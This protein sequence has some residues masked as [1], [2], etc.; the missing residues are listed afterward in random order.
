MPEA[1]TASMAGPPPRPRLRPGVAV[2]PLAAGLHLRGRGAAVTLEGSRALPF[3]WKLLSARLAADPVAGTAESTE[4]ADPR[5]EAA[6]TTL[7]ARL[8]EHDL[9]VEHPDGAE[10]P[11]WPGSSAADPVRAAEAI[12][13]AR[14]VIATPHPHSPLA[15][16]LA[17]ALNDA[18]ASP[19]LTVDGRLAVGQAVITADTPSGAVA[20]AVSCDADGGFVTEPGPPGHARSEADAV[21][22]RLR[23]GTQPWTPPGSPLPAPHQASTPSCTHVSLLAGAAAGRLL[24]AVAGLPDPAAQEN[25]STSAATGHPAVLIARAEPPEATYH[26]WAGAPRTARR[27]PQA[28]RDLAEALRRITAL[29]DPRLGVL[30][31]PLPGNLPQLP[32]SLVSCRTGAG[33]LVAGAGRADQARLEAACHAAELAL[34]DASGTPV[35]GATPGHAHGRALRRALLHGAAPT[36]SGGIADDVWNSHPQARHWWTVLTERMG[37]QAEL[38]VRRLGS[39]QAHTAVVRV[40]A[41]APAPSGGRTP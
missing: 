16:G 30:D 28:P 6:L 1:P 38:S 9:L 10:L 37:R 15:R 36:A 18:G 12:R 25:A 14:P 41:P 34:A 23:P 17:R 24:A 33:P 40:R 27:R 13:A 20:L 21:A 32:A 4:T 2:T 19:R 29:T 35:V 3:L 22:A 31:A 8:R 26:P 39:E 7:T 5:V 11:P